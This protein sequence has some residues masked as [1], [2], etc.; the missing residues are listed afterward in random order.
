MITPQ[1][2]EIAVPD[3]FVRSSLSDSFQQTLDLIKNAESLPSCAK[4]ATSA[5]M[6]S[7]SA[8]EGS[9]KQDE[10]ALDRGTDLFVDE[11]ADIYSA[12]LAVCELSGAD[13][14]IPK[15]C[16][17]FIP[18]EKATKKRGFRGY[19]SKSGPTEPNSLFQYYDEITQANLQQCRKALGSTSQSWTSYSN[20]RQN[21]VLMCRAMRSE[22]EKEE[23]LHTGKILAGAAMTATSSFQE[24]L[25]QAN[26]MKKVFHEVAT[27]MPQFQQDLVAGDEERLE[28]V[29][30]FWFEIERVQKG[31]QEVLGSVREVKDEL[32]N[33]GGHAKDLES[34]ISTANDSA[35]EITD[36]VAGAGRQVAELTGQAE[37]FVN[38]IEYIRTVALH[39]I[40]KRLYNMTQDI[41][42]VNAIMPA[43]HRQITAIYDSS[44]QMHQ[45]HEAYLVRTSTLAGQ[46]V[47]KLETANATISGFLNVSWLPMNALEPLKLA[48]SFLG[49]AFVYSLIGFGVWER[50]IGFSFLGNVAASVGTGC[51]KSLGLLLCQS[52]AD[53]ATGMAFVST[54]VL[55]PSEFCE[56]IANQSANS[57]YDNKLA[58]ALCLGLVAGIVLAAVWSTLVRAFRGKMH[59]AQGKGSA[60]YDPASPKFTPRRWDV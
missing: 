15:E 32:R 44:M 46:I 5:L 13:F 11:E 6:H 55:S 50:V 41:D 49:Y 31:F 52:S 40:T 35:T 18:T 21:A 16:K 9:M 60:E 8:L 38:V 17:P 4:I 7:C 47:D 33:V 58:L 10:S 14:L 57:Y 56:A 34:T 30:Q 26:E 27:S 48:A 53:N 36:L 24:V 1:V 3:T 39:E 12:R 45:E 28:K 54:F 20:N 37:D 2:S 51:G 22:I 42:V 19:W 43:V 23:Q 25:E 29:R 59:S